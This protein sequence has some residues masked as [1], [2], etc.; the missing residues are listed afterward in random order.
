MIAPRI[1]I[2]TAVVCAA[3][4]VSAQQQPVFRTGVQVVEVDARVFDKEGNFVTTLTRDDFEI[5]E[6]GVTQTIVLTSLIGGSAGSVGSGGS[7]GSVPVERA[8]PTERLVP[9]SRQTWIFFFDLNHLTPGGGFDRAKSSVEAFVKA[10]LPAGDMAGVV[11]GDQMVGGRLTSV[12]EEILSHVRQVKARGDSRARMIELT[13]E[14][15]RFRNEEEAMQVARR[16]EEV[17]QR[18]LTRACSDDPGSCTMAE[19]MVDQKA[20][21]LA[22]TIQKETHETFAALN[23]LASGLARVPGPKTVVFLSNGF[24]SFGFE[25]TLRTLVGQTARSGARVYAI[26]VRGLDRSGQGDMLDAVRFDDAAG[27][28]PKF[29][30]LE[31]GVN[32]LAVDTGGLMIRNENNIGRALTQVAADAGT[33]YVIGYQPANTSFDGKYRKVE[34]RVKQPNLKVRARQ[35]YLALEPSKMLVPERIR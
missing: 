32:S 28:P 4:A 9:G 10:Q 23:G 1:L 30:A 25:N 19:S 18:V 12:R 24:P 21:G 33:Y 34:V 35:G 22:S 7:A 27:G 8:E 26:D 16:I 17:R 13:R 20:A 5:L 15:P 6:D 14:W 29:D 2:M 31:D 11:A 3:A